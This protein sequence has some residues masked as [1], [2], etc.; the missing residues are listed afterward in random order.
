[1]SLKTISPAQAKDLMN[2]GAVLVDI[3]DAD[4]HAREHIP[5]ATNLA[6]SEIK[7]GHPELEN[8]RAVIY[9]C[10][11]GA[12]TMANGE[13]A[14]VGINTISRLAR[15]RQQERSSTNEVL[16]CE[17]PCCAIRRCGVAD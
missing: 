9:H 12:R 8:D 14:Q 15:L 13:A 5:G 16:F 17:N 11:S 2:Q 1:M 10:R 7:Q 3:R 6:L 4:E